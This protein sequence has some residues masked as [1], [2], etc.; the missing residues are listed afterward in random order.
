MLLTSDTFALEEIV[1]RN[2]I[3]ARWFLPFTIHRLRPQSVNRS[4]VLALSLF[5][6]PGKPQATRLQITWLPES[7]A[8]NVPPV[9]EHVITEWAACGVACAMIPIYTG[10]QVLQVT[11][12]GDGFDYWVGNEDQEYGLEVSGTM[13]VEIEQRHRAKVRQLSQGPHEVGGYIS[14]TSFRTMNSILSF[15]QQQGVADE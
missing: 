8:L 7:A 4:A 15:H 3:D 14:I 11:Q 13:G 10:L 1:T 2:A 6:I 12:S 5:D 9:Q